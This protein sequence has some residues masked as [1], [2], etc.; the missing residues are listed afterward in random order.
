MYVP[1]YLSRA[2]C[3][4]SDS[5]SLQDFQKFEEEKTQFFKK[6]MQ[7]YMN[8]FN[9]F[10]GQLSSTCETLNKVVA[11]IDEAADVAT[12]ISDNKASAVTPP[13][14]IDY[15]PYD[16]EYKGKNEGTTKKYFRF[17]CSCY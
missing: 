17:D 9:Q 10:P 16:S 11:A 8:S 6:I 14:T 3:E 5:S 7:D 13:P 4:V 2:I 15:E 1:D 12:F